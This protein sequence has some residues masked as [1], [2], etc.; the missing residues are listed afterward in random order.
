MEEILPPPPIDPNN[1]KVPALLKPTQ[2]NLNKPSLVLGLFLHFR[3]D[4]PK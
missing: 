3:V 1:I 2:K 4:T